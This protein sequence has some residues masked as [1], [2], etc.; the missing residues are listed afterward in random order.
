MDGGIHSIG[1]GREALFGNKR[2]KSVRFSPANQMEVDPSDLENGQILQLQQRIIEGR[3]KVGVGRKKA[4][5]NNRTHA[6][7]RP[8]YKL[9]S[10]V[11]RHSKAAGAGSLDR[12]RI[13]YTCTAD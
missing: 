11:R 8:R 4:S 2:G 13:G 5:M 9:G 10:F 6:I 1:Y 7:I 3:V 12:R